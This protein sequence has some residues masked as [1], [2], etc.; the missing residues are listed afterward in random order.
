MENHKS[1]KR[2]GRILYLLFPVMFTGLEGALICLNQV[3]YV[4][5]LYYYLAGGFLALNAVGVV[6][7][8]KVSFMLSDYMHEMKE[9]AKN[10]KRFD[11][12]EL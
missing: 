7:L 4:R 1:L 9:N 5:N 8:M 11:Y 2:I 3:E 6:V 12:L 10:G